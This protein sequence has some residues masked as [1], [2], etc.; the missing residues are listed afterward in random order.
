MATV[1]PR[2]K[3]LPQPFK[4]LPATPA[5]FRLGEEGMP[6]SPLAFPMESG[7]ADDALATRDSA[8]EFAPGLDDREKG[9]A[10]EMESL[11]AAMMTVDNGFEDQWWYQGPRLVSVAGDLIS[12]TA[13]G[14][15][16]PR[17]A[18]NS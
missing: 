6:W 11:A 3:P 4:A 17:N 8:P 5:Q 13:L 10:W 7:D 1:L 12:P 9:R 2:R 16:N 15:F 18:I 14:A